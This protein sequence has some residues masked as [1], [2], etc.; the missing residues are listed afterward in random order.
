MS[1][2]HRGSREPGET[3]AASHA[4]EWEPQNGAAA[5]LIDRSVVASF[6]TAGPGGLA[7][8]HLP[9]LLDR[10]RSPHGCLVSHLAAA[11]SHAALVAAG[12]PSVAIFKAEQGYISSSWYPAAPVRDSAPTW[13][14][15]VVHC[16]GRPKVL[17]AAAL[18]RHLADLVEHLERG[19]EGAWN[20]GELGPGG[21]AR[22]MPHIIGFELP[23]ERLDAKFKM[24]AGRARPRY[25]SRGRA[26]GR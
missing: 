17:G 14:F 11:N 21:M 1:G 16:H 8:S 15:A 9:F 6:V 2:R 4:P 12:L 18:A 25:E 7:V 24:G 20:L 5:D 26:P 23:I 3:G 19:R 22:R 13:N 10:S